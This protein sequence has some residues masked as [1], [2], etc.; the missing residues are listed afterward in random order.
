MTLI[1]ITNLTTAIYGV[2]YLVAGMEKVNHTPPDCVY[3]CWIHNAKESDCPFSGKYN[4][5]FFFGMYVLTQPTRL[6]TVSYQVEPF[7]V[8]SPFIGP[9]WLN[10]NNFM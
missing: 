5:C 3:L 9:K 6:L 10:I 2:K 1:E 8:D 4:P 7:E